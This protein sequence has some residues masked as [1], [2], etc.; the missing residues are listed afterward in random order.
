MQL[1]DI[2][3]FGGDGQR[4]NQWKMGVVQELIPGKDEEVLEER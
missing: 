2:V 1:G 4:H 3:L